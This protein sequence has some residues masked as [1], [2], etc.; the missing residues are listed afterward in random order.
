MKWPLLA[1]AASQLAVLLANFFIFGVLGKRLSPTDF[2]YYALGMSVV[3]FVRQCTFDPVSTVIG[4]DNAVAAAREYQLTGRFSIMAYIADRMAAVMFAVGVFLTI[5]L[6]SF[7][8]AEMVVIVVALSAYLVANGAL[9][10]YV[11]SLYSIRD[12]A[13]PSAAVSV[14]SIL[15]AITVFAMGGLVYFSLE[16]VVVA[17]AISALFSISVLRWS[18]RRK[19]RLPANFVPR[20]R[21]IAGV[22]VR[23]LPLFIPCVLVA[24]KGVSDRWI[25][26]GVLGVEK[27]AGYNVVYQLGFTP[28]VLAIG[29]VQ[30]YLGPEIYRRCLDGSREAR[31]A[32]MQYL[33]RLLVG[34]VLL[35]VF[36]TFFS[37][38]FSKDLVV[39]VVGSGY[40]DYSRY[41][42]WFVFAGFLHAFL[43]ILYVASLGAFDTKTVA[44]LSAASVFITCSVGVL[45]VLAWG[46]AGGVVGLV[47]SG[48]LAGFVYWLALRYT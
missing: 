14:D 27:L 34:I 2:G 33:S 36:A 48:I 40:V 28:V 20:Q 4:K 46:F 6:I 7:G 47:V 18:L 30:T 42:P 39:L 25:F 24:L 37:W 44:S 16:S 12:R 21:R 43:G 38:V 11:N 23:A 22:F 3:L 26:A 29:V 15:R 31:S 1:I 41:L 45:S 9:G 17:I 13:L 32:L 19:Y 35:G 8:K 10:L 5:L